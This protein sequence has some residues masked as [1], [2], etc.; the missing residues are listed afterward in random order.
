MQRSLSLT[1]GY[2][3]SWEDGREDRDEIKLGL[4]LDLGFPENE[5][6]PGAGRLFDPAGFP[7]Q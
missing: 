5:Q 4:Q 2:T 7:E 3:R 1:G 6:L